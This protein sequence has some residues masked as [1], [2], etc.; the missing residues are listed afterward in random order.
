MYDA[1]TGKILSAYGASLDEVSL[2]KDPGGVNTSWDI[3]CSDI[4][5]D[6]Y[7]RQIYS[8]MER[9]QKRPVLAGKK[10]GKGEF[11]KSFKF[12]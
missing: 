4:S 9:P 5:V 3:E 7:K 12:F 10:A 8:R 2:V 1:N 11:E 6:V